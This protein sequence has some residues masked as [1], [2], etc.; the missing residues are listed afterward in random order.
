MRI[1][2]LFVQKT[3]N[4]LVGL[5]LFIF[6]FVVLLLPFLF[7]TIA[8]LFVKKK[9]TAWVRTTKNTFDPNSPY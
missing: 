8:Q 1:L 4:A 6:Y 9:N 5:V 7:I 3:N 2:R